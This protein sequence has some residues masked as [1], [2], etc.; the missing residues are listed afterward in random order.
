MFGLRRPA[1]RRPADPFL[2]RPVSAPGFRKRGSTFWRRVDRGVLCGAA[3]V[4]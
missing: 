4:P 2:P 3:Q 1:L